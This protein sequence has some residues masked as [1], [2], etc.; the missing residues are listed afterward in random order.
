MQASLTRH[1]PAPFVTCAYVPAA[2]EGLPLSAVKALPE[3]V[4]RR[5]SKQ[6]A[7][8]PPRG[9][10]EIE[11][12]AFA[13]LLSDEPSW[14]LLLGDGLDRRQFRQGLLRRF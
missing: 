5:R 7:N 10:R 3:G 14:C 4:E 12:S 8:T 11:P 2:G 9:V 1:D 6:V 13:S